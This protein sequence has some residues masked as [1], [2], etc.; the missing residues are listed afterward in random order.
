[1]SCSSASTGYLSDETDVGSDL[2][3]FASSVSSN[4]SQSLNDVSLNC[5]DKFTN[6]GNF[7]K[8]NSNIRD[9]PCSWHYGSASSYESTDSG[10]NCA[11]GSKLHHR[12]VITEPI[13]YFK[14][15]GSG[16]KD[17]QPWLKS[18]RLHKYSELFSAMTYEQMM[19]LTEEELELKGVTKGARHKIILNINKLKNRVDNLRALEQSLDEEGYAFV[20][21]ALNE[22][23][24]I[25]AT[26]IKPY[27]PM[28]SD[29]N[30]NS[31]QSANKS[32]SRF[33]NLKMDK[34][35][36]SLSQIQLTSI[37]SNEFNSNVPDDNDLPSQLTRVLS[38]SKLTSLL[39]IS[40]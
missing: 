23:K 20:R 5:A 7:M 16:M 40:Q 12:P 8:Q 14:V 38:K 10:N 13:N 21:Q 29:C 25:L 32:L 34:Y 3:V 30:N 33:G 39:F 26:P 31:V 22:L 15:D 19:S 11:N 18:L 9:R 4:C 37:Y 2:V 17:V 35:S 36:S 6:S 1:M 24:N 27:N 28:T